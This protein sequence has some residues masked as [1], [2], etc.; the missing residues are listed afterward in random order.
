MGAVINKTREGL[1]VTN[2]PTFF[3]SPWLILLFVNLSRVTFDYRVAVFCNKKV[4]KPTPTIHFP[5][6]QMSVVS[7]LHGVP[8]MTLS[9]NL[10]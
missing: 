9:F 2:W 3:K 1:N 10:K 7:W 4:L 6:T 5:S 8:S